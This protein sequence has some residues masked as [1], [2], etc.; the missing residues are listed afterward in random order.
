MAYIG[1]MNDDDLTQDE[2]A[3]YDAVLEDETRRA[4]NEWFFEQDQPKNL[5][6]GA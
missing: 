4:L 2:E 1:A 3:R 6:G 5:G